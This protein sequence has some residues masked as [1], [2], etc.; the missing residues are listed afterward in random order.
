MWLAK[1]SRQLLFPHNSFHH[2]CFHTSTRSLYPSIHRHYRRCGSNA[3]VWKQN[4][5]PHLQSVLNIDNT[6]MSIFYLHYTILNWFSAISH[7]KTLQTYC[8][9]TAK[10]LQWYCK[11]ICSAA[12]SNMQWYCKQY[13]V[14]LQN[15][16]SKFAASKLKL[17]SEWTDFKGEVYD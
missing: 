16:C 9:D 4:L 1:Q 17:N 7:C 13:A 12:A 11:L 14:V 6:P 15:V 3:K 8:S 10:L 2:F 5:L